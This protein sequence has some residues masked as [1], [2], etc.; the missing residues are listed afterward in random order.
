M[1]AEYIYRSELSP[2]AVVLLQNTTLPT[3]NTDLFTPITLIGPTTKIGAFEVYFSSTVGGTLKLSRTVNGVTEYE[4]LNHGIAC[5][6][7]IPTEPQIVT[8]SGGEVIGMIY[9]G[10]GGTCYLT[11][12]DV[13]GDI[14]QKQRC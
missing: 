5:T 2:N 13:S 7:N 14:V 11:V 8:V 3:A 10:T 1:A 12:A 6:A 4:T 9:S